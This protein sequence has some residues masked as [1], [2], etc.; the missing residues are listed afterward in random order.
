MK[1]L[2]VNRGRVLDSDERVPRCGNCRY[3][4]THIV[5]PPVCVCPSKRE[6]DYV[7]VE[8]Q[9]CRLWESKEVGNEA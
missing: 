7:E 2:R 8:R 3:C 1:K 4:A 6:I 5:V 9:A